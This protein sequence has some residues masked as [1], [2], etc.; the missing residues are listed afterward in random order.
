MDEVGDNRRPSWG[1]RKY[2]RGVLGKD[3]GRRGDTAGQ[4]RRV[5]ITRDTHLEEKALISW[6]WS[7]P[8]LMMMMMRADFINPQNVPGPWEH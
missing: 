3:K 4:K 5:Q 1:F 2:G 6:I 7:L 8:S